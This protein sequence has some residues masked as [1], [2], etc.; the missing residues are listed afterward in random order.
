MFYGI[1]A[2][3]KNGDT[4]LTAPVISEEFNG[5]N[6]DNQGTRRPRH[7]RAFQKGLWEMI[8]EN[9]TSRIFLGVHWIF[10]AFD[11]TVDS[12]GN[13]IPDLTNE[14]IGGVPLGLRIARD[15]FAAGLG[16]APKM[17]P[18]GS[19]IPPIITPPANSPMVQNPRQP[20]S[21]NGCAGPVFSGGSTDDAPI[22]IGEEKEL[23]SV[24]EPYPKGV[25]DD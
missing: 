23:E 14:N 7:A 2:N 16:K 24:Q 5:G 17:T 18:S 20:Y 11:F 25:S 19:A 10:D 9:A 12:N 4:L 22:E 15:I 8:I 13:Y 21:I 6:S 1:A 3:D